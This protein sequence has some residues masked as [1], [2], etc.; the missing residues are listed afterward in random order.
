[1]GRQRSNNESNEIY[2]SDLSH[3]LLSIHLSLLK[4]DFSFYT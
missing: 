3:Q 2:T 4:Y 1:M